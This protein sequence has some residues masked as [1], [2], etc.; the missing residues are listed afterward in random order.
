MRSLESLLN[1]FINLER[2]GEFHYG[3]TLERMSSL[4]QRLGNPQSGTYDTIVVAGSKGKTSTATYLAGMLQAA[5]LKVGLYT[6]PHL[7]TW[8]ERIR[9]NGEPITEAEALAEFSRHESSFVIAQ[10]PARPTYFEVM[11]GLAFL[12]F[13]SQKIDVAVLEVGLGGRFDATNVVDSVMSVITPIGLEHQIILGDTINEIAYEKA[14][15]IK[16][17]QVVHSAPQRLEAGE[18]IQEAAQQKNSVVKILSE[19]RF[20]GDS[21]KALGEH[22]LLNASLALN[23]AEGYLRSKKIQ[24]IQDT[25][26][27][28]AEDKV[29]EG[30]FEIL[31]QC[32]LLIVDGAHNVDSAKAL[33]KT[34]L[35]HYPNL[36]WNL[37]IG[38]FR[39]K[40]P[41]EFLQE[42][43]SIALKRIIAVPVDS[44]RSFTAQELI[45]AINSHPEHFAS[46]EHRLRDGSQD[47]SA[48]TQNDRFKNIEIALSI[49]DALDQL[50]RAGDTTPTLI[51]GSLYLVGAAKQAALGEI[52]RAS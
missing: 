31:S 24:F 11:T 23:V 30:R 46:L 25:L 20:E 41:K 38:M 3:R 45:S 34:I 9:V 51:T 7:L 18:V 16:D 37:I 42:L 19:S 22:Q 36:K 35:H 13:K 14:G 33:S 21:L 48:A 17:C 43:K 6:S 8:H 27:K 32:P 15:I 52:E 2:T 47:S 50:N 28:S 29:M 1:Q 44:Y 39:D 49:E 12:Y 5:G 10:S 4:C 40:K 26:K